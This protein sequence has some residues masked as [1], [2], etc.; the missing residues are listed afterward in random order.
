MKLTHK[1]RTYWRTNLA[2]TAVLLV[3]WFC[4]TF[5]TGYFAIPLN[6]YEF[7]GFPLGFYIFSQG[8]LLVFLLIIVI[9]VWVMNRLDY[10]YGV[11]ER[12]GGRRGQ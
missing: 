7:L 12:N 1:H 8:A 4:V 5:V 9:Y 11:A 6:Q 3:V 2:L 10:K